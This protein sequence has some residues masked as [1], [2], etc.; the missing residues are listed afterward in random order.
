VAEGAP[1]SESQTEGAPPETPSVRRRLAKWAAA[2]AVLAVLIALVLPVVSMLQPGYHSRYP[3]LRDRMEHWSVSTHSRI[4][5]AECHIKPG[6]V[7]FLAFAAK[8][9]PAFYAQLVRGPGS[10]DI[11]DAPEREACQRCHTAY[12]SV[13]PAGDLLIPHKAHVEILGMQC[14]TCH[15]DLVHSLNRRGFNRPEM[16]GCLERCHDGDT[17]SNECLDCHTRKQAPENHAREDWLLVHSEMIDTIDCAE[18]HDWTPEYCAECHEKRPASHV[19]NWK[20]GHAL[21]AEERGDGCLV[22]H[23]GEEF[24]AECH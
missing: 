3:E 21:V 8:S 20:K 11:L 16:E 17:A 19:G 9:V 4:S 24:C 13:S 23:G 22:C 18:C 1:T 7:P 5:C 6:A 2:A 15:E 12:R 10:E 14:V